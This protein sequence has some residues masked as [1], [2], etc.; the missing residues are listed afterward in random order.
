METIPNYQLPEGHFLAV[1]AV[2]SIEGRLL[3]DHGWSTQECFVWPGLRGTATV[4][5]WVPNAWCGNGLHAYPW[6]DWREG[7][8]YLYGSTILVLEVPVADAVRIDEI[9]IKF[10]SCR[11]VGIF[12]NT[13]VEVVKTFV[14]QHDPRPPWTGHHPFLDDPRVQEVREYVVPY[15]PMSSRPLDHYPTPTNPLGYQRGEKPKR[16]GQRRWFSRRKGARHH[17]ARRD[18]AAVGLNSNNRVVRLLRTPSPTG[19]SK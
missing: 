14:A 9:K 6:C 7:D 2:R 12:R 10:P 1:K 18:L 13:G 3:S 19:E 8:V 17:S 16:M 5:H 4:G 15:D 11:V